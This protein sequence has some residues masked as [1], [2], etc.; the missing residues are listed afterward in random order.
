MNYTNTLKAQP[1]GASAAAAAARRSTLMPPPP[2]RRASHRT[3]TDGLNRASYINAVAQPVGGGALVHRDIDE[4]V[5]RA[6]YFNA[7]PGMPLRQASVS[8]V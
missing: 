8:L 3:G 4:N 5:S 7:M 6:S 2:P 1:V